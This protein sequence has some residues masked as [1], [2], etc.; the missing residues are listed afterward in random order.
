MMEERI[1]SALD[2]RYREGHAGTNLEITRAN[3][4]NADGMD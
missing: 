1:I 4:R 2:S 3:R